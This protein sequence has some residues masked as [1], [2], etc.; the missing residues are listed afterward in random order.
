LARKH[1]RLQ[2]LLLVVSQFGQVDVSADVK[3]DA[4]PVAKTDTKSVLP[5]DF[6]IA[7]HGYFV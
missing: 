5:A 1:L 3:P 4:K 6:N 2:R 7:I